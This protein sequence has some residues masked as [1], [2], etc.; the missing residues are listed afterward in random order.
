MDL[1]EMA[2]DTEMPLP[3]QPRCRSDYSSPDGLL[4]SS[5]LWAQPILGG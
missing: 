1:D 2:K 4:A 5:S 3:F